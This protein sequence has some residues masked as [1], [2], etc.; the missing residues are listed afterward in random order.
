MTEVTLNLDGV[1]TKVTTEDEGIAAWDLLMLL[2]GQMR[3]QTF[4]E[5]VVNKALVEYV[6]E[7]VK[8]DNNG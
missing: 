5:T 3:A 1:I 4:S 7:Y 8:S 2:V 6:N